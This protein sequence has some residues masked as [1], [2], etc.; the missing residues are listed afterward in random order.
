[1]TSLKITPLLG[2]KKKNQTQPTTKPT[3]ST[4]GDCRG[5]ALPAS[6][7]P[8]SGRN[9]AEPGQTLPAGLEPAYWDPTPPMTLREKQRV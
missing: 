7:P 6:G 4:P 1:M 5:E 3:S 9:G 2:E 8:K